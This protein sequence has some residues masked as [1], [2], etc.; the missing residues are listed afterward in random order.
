MRLYE[1]E[2]STLIQKDTPVF[3]GI[4]WDAEPMLE[5]LG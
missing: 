4:P 5:Q 2:N 1:T 3:T